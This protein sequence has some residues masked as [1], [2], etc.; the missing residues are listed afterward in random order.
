V[1]VRAF[2][3]WIWDGLLGREEIAGRHNIIGVGALFK[4]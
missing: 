1:V 3:F 4:G 2:L